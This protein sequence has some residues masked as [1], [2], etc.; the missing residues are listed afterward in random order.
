MINYKEIVDFHKNNFNSVKMALEVLEETIIEGRDRLEDR[1]PIYAT[2]YRIKSVNSIYLKTKRQK[3]SDFKQIT[4]Y[5]G[6]RILC[7]AEQDLPKVNEF[8]I[9]L[10]KEKKWILSQIKI[11]NFDLEQTQI[12]DKQI[13]N[14]II[15]SNDSKKNFICSRDYK[16]SGYKSIHYILERSNDGMPTV[17]IQLRTLLQDV[18]GELEHSLAYKKGQVNPYIKK[19]FSLLAQDLATCDSLIKHLKEIRDKDN[20]GR[21]YSL[22]KTCPYGYLEYENELLP[23]IFKDEKKQGEYVQ[24][25]QKY[26][27]WVREEGRL[28]K[29]RAEWLKSSMT[30][31][32]QIIKKVPGEYHDS[33][34]Q[35]IYW[36]EITHLQTIL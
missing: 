5:G 15:Q 16:E 36:K 22:N 20:A 18:W 13:D 8:I 28:D 12:F 14:L 30:K 33:N 32:D 34:D 17:E 29:N 11:Y 3:I 19:N 9:E 7:L 31:L 10:L 23:E 25:Y 27:A 26:S 24:L 21:L 6:M 35:F 4:D 2:K 1:I